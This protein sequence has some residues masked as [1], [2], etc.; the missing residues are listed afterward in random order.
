MNPQPLPL[1][2]QPAALHLHTISPGLQSLETASPEANDLFFQQRYAHQLASSPHA[3]QFQGHA[4]QQGPPPFPQFPTTGSY[5]RAFE[6]S[7][8]PAPPQQHIQPS[9]RPPVHPQPP[10][11]PPPIQG[12]PQ[13]IREIEL[14]PEFAPPQEQ[15]QGAINTQDPD[16]APVSNHGQFEGLKL[17]PNPPD[18]DAWREKLFHVDDTITLTEE[19]CASP[20]RPSSAS[21]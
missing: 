4:L 8:P 16:E 6:L 10:P 7:A 21:F 18:L 12:P 9:T 14:R 13:P 1:H 20:F 5:G 17:I 19:E 2:L 3:L 11:Q 15:G